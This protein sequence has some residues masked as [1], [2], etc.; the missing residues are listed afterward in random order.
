MKLDQL[1]NKLLAAARLDAP[2]DHVPYAF[3]QRIMARLATHTVA[4]DWALWAAALWRAAAPCVAVVL[5][6][7]V[8]TFI[9]TRSGADSTTLAAAL[10]DAVLAPTDDAN[11]SW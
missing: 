2:S 1:Q 4:D 10:E 6:L 3:E 8:W 7:G 5:L 11:E 9:E